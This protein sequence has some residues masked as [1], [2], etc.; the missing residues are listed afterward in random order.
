MGKK[1]KRPRIQPS[2][3]PHKRA[4]PA[5]P[6]TTNKTSRVVIDDH[7]PQPHLQSRPHPVLARYYP[8]LINLRSYLLALLPLTSVA[9]RQSISSL[10][11]SSSPP[12]QQPDAG[13]DH[14]DRDDADEE[15][16]A[17]LRE[18][19]ALLDTTLVGVSKPPD[20]ASTHARQRELAAFNQSQVVRGTDVGATTALG[21]VS[22]IVFPFVF[23]SRRTDVHCLFQ[24]YCIHKEL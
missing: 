6:P 2:S 4:K 13:Y 20:H 10:G 3:R 23:M 9:R 11:I 24:W 21:E 19:A 1:R 22:L 12:K 8:R 15:R 14:R 5:P 7:P 18:V 17:R 16:R